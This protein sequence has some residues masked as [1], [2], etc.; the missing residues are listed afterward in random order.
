MGVDISAARFLRSEQDRGV[1]F[2]R[3]LTLGRQHLY[4]TPGEFRKVCPECTRPE[5]TD[6]CQ[7]FFSF[8]GARA[9]EAID[10]S[11]YEGANMI[12]DMNDPLVIPSEQRWSCVFD[13]G[14]LEHIF[15][16]P[17]AIKNCLEATAVGG[18]FISITPW[19]GWSGHGFYQFC[20]ELFY[21][22]LSEENGFK[23]ERML[24]RDKKRWYHVRDPKLLGHR[25]E[26]QSSERR[27]L[28]ISARR[29]EE[30]PVFATYPQQS[31]YAAAW[32]ST[33]RQHETSSGTRWTAALASLFP[34]WST[35]VQRKRAERRLM[36][37]AVEEVPL[38]VES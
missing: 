16:F 34:G 17:Q 12:H 38:A 31:D 8:L 26:F 37:T 14:S 24:F 2:A 9:I 7:S 5:P 3:T 13:G 22:I 25:V 35:Y 11:S 15:N 28:Y 20:P 4:M 21:R 18:H 29:T 23:V 32:T 27:L 1:S 19:S 6:S 36:Q 10:A 33:H 30:R